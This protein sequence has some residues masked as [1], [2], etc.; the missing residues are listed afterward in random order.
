MKN[1][2]GKIPSLEKDNKIIFVFASIFLIAIFLATGALIV[3]VNK[4]AG[5]EKTPKPVTLELKPQPESNPAPTLD[6]SQWVFE[7]LN[8]SGIAGAAGKA[9]KKLE[10]LGYTVV[11]IGNADKQN[12]PTTQLFVAKKQFDNADLLMEH[13]KTEFPSVTLS[14]KLATDSTAS[15]RIIVGRE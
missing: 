4:F 5:E 11:E 13:L 2:K 1:N 15:A 8:G 14:G 12:Y 3:A 10:T 7:V 9:A 6:K